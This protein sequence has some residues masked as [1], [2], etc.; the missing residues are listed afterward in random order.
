MIDDLQVVALVLGVNKSA[1]ALAISVEKAYHQIPQITDAV[2]DF[3]S[4]MAKRM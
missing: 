4:M 3:A 2:F 1:Y